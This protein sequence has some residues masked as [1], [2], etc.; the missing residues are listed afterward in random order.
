MSFYHKDKIKRHFDK[1]GL[2]AAILLLLST[3]TLSSQD[4]K[5]PRR[6]RRNRSMQI[7]V[8]DSSSLPELSDSA[9]FALDSIHHADSIHRSDSIQMLHKSSLE[10]PAFTT[11]RDSIIEDFSDGKQMIYYYGDVTVKYGNME[12]TAD[13]MEYDLKTNT[14]FARGTK[15]SGKQVLHNGGGPL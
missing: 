15:D 10:S 12:L 11:A 6:E 3:F 9:R 14:L 5:R 8:S 13:Y 1:L 2:M 7:S 4:D